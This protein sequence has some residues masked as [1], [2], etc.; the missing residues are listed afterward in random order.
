MF[1]STV[2]SPDEKKT[3]ICIFADPH[4]C[5]KESLAGSDRKPKRS[6][7]KMRA[8]VEN[9]VHEGVS[10]IVCLGDFINREETAEQDFKNAETAA[11]VLNAVRI[12]VICCMG[13]HDCESFTAEE[14]RKVTGF[15]TAP[16]FLDLPSGKRLVFLDANFDRFLQPYRKHQVDWTDANVSSGQLAWL[17]EVLSGR[18]AELFIHQNLEPDAEPRHRV[19]NASEVLE[20]LLKNDVPRVWQGHYH[21]GAERQY[22]GIEFVTL[23]AMCVFEDTERFVEL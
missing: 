1:S 10:L 23:K 21:Y 16:C 9:D 19:R 14:F 8:M 5:T 3:K 2:R 18:T 7:D 22:E 15:R 20:I 6:L 12:P 4:Y 11:A 17:K 13:N